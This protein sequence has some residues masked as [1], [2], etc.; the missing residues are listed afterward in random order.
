MEDVITLELN[1]GVIPEAILSRIRI[2]ISINMNIQ[3]ISENRVVVSIAAFVLLFGL[4]SYAKPAFLFFPDGSL[5][6]FGVGYKN[7]TILP[8]W[9]IAVLLGILC[10]IG[11]LYVGALWR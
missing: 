4:L 6:E 7:K 1:R 5:R 8:L 10:Y 11:V 2:Y 9:L 3:W